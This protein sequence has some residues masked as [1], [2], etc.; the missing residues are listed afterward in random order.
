[1]LT[2]A[3]RRVSRGRAGAALAVLVLLSPW[4][5]ARAQ[6]PA[7]PESPL[8][9]IDAVQAAISQHPSLEIQRQQVAI[10]EAVQQQVSAS[11]DQIL[12]T[13][14]DRGQ[15]YQPFS[16]AAGIGLGAANTAQI[17]ASYSKL[18]RNGMSLGG[19]LD[20]QRQIRSPSSISGLT[21][22]A[23]RLQLGVP[24]L[25]GRGVQVTTANER[26]AGL[27]REGET[28]DLRHVTAVAMSRAASSY[29]GLVAAARSRDV[30]A[31]SDRRGEQLVSNTRALIDADQ[32]PRADL[33]ST[34]ANAADRRATRFAAD[35]D[36]FAARQR[37]M[38]DMGLRRDAWPD[39]LAL[40]DFAVLGPLPAVD[41]LPRDASPWIEEA[42]RRRA[43]YLAAQV[44]VEAA[45]VTRD[46]ATNALLPR[47]DLQLAVGYTALSEGRQFNRYFAALGDNV[48]G[49]DAF[50]GISYRFPLEN[51]QARGQVAE[52]GAL[53][54][55]ATTTLADLERTIRSSI[56]ESY[57][58]VRNALLGLAQARESVAAFEEALR[59]EQEKL[60]L[61]RGSIVNLLTIEDRL[62][63]ASGREVAAWRSYAQALVDFRFA[64]GTLVPARDPLPPLPD[65]TTFTT[66][67]VSFVGG[68]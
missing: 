8:R 18:L 58:A 22:S 24:L 39:A 27:V 21:T 9:L 7:A 17:A 57:S 30:A 46:A 63:T 34:L 23:T 20:M 55:Q 29:W 13:S 42:L 45:R 35:Q 33:A 43:D 32:S 53:L 38:L 37:L 36:Y 52:A 62:T 64:T 26:A 10:S 14:L 54:L 25:R 19:A 60:A 31:A 2:P 5:P 1:M 47:V 41:T 3:L 49:L 61:G 59:G 44:R 40:D 68:K 65:L 67:P 56:A 51:R 66:L 28:L 11:F 12:T 4:R 15:I 48:E 6:T 50:G 16:S